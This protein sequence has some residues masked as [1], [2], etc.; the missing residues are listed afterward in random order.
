[1]KLNLLDL[2]QTAQEN[3][4]GLTRSLNGT[5][6]EKKAFP[7][8][9]AYADK[10]EFENLTADI[11]TIKKIIERIPSI[12]GIDQKKLK[13]IYGFNGNQSSPLD[14]QFIQNASRYFRPD[15]ILTDQGPKILEFNIDSGCVQFQLYQTLVNLYETNDSFQQF[16]RD[17]FRADFKSFFQLDQQF[18]KSIQAQKK[19]DHYYFWDVKRDES[20]SRQIKSA[21]T[22][23]SRLGIN[24]KFIADI[25]GLNDLYNKE[26]TYIHRNFAYIHAIKEKLN[27]D[28]VLSKSPELSPLLPLVLDSK[29]NMAL[30]FEDIIYKTLSAEEKSAVER[31]I[32]ETKRCTSAQKSSKDHVFKKGTSFQGK[33]TFV[34]GFTESDFP[35]NMQYWIQQKKVYPN[36]PETLFTNGES[37]IRASKNHVFNIHFID[38][39]PVS[40]F[41]RINLESDDKV[42]A[43]NN[44]TTGLIPFLR[45]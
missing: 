13:D 6:S 34:S 44:I 33:N 3:L 9:I 45:K 17:T 21:A 20:V 11:V 40:A 27:D 22:K 12:L 10:N 30:I 1:M 14:L 41:F 31:L 29:L 28:N 24:F 37:L 15:L 2:P 39:Q 4:I 26:T 19:Y 16:V 35:E 36:L 43:V 18:I 5:S 7:L 32:P 25:D 23:L 8:Q 42:G 38:N